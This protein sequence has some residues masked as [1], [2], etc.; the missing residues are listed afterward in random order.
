[1]L[2]APQ[3][4]RFKIL[5]REIKA[6]RW[7]MIFGALSD[8]TRFCIFE[9]LCRS[10]DL[11]VTDI[12]QICNLSIAAASHQLKILEM[13]G[14][15]ERIRHGKMICYEVK[16]ANPIVKAITKIFLENKLEIRN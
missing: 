1:M 8:P 7:P 4:K 10:R 11:C 6:K 2:N 9:I 3:I 12:A 15:V 5:S 16:T 13:V 14:L